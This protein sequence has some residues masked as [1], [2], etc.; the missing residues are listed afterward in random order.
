MSSV[1]LVEAVPPSAVF[2]EHFIDCIDSL[3][4]D[5][6]RNVSQ[7]RELDLLYRG[8]LSQISNLLDLYNSTDDQTVKQRYLTKIQRCLIKSQEY[9]DEKL[10]LISHIVEVVDNKNIQIIKDAENMDTPIRREASPLINKPD[11][12]VNFDD[13]RGVER[14]PPTKRPRRQKT[15][16]E[17]FV[18]IQ[19]HLLK[20]EKIPKIEKSSK[21]EKSTRSEKK[22]KTTEK[23]SESLESSNLGASSNTEVVS[24]K[25]N[26]TTK[27]ER[28]GTTG[29]KK[30]GKQKETKKKNGNVKKK[31]KKELADIPIDPDE[32]TYCSCNQ[33]SFGEM[34]GCD[35]EECPIEW[36]HF[37]CVNLTVK[38]KGKWYCPQCTIERREKGKK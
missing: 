16:S 23:L 11:H 8:K 7:L 10:Q 31:K 4:N 3:P 17:K 2:I 24:K 18:D 15:V 1:N 26:E 38:P 9:G 27:K 30:T 20:P 12:P 37:S 36:F 29:K 25:S 13:H 21:A 22:S 32:P 6:Q 35:N 14:H 33:V 19:E 28:E 34:I 5:V